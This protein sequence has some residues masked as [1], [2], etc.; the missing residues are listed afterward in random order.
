MNKLDTLFM[1]LFCVFV[2]LLCTLYTQRPVSR[3]SVLVCKLPDIHYSVTV[4]HK[5]NCR[6]KL[7]FVYRQK[8]LWSNADVCQIPNVDIFS[9]S[10]GSQ[11]SALLCVETLQQECVFIEHEN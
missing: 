7:D 1:M 5:L 9:E 3:C 6:L 4:I 2:K 11:D 10:F 8:H